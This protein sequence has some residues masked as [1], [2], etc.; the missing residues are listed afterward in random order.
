MSLI[1]RRARCG[2][3]GVLNLIIARGRG[4]LAEGDVTPH[5]VGNLYHYACV[6][7]RAEGALSMLPVPHLGAPLESQPPRPMGDIR[8]IARRRPRE[9]PGRLGVTYVDLCKA[10]ASSDPRPVG[11]LPADTS[12]LAGH[13]LTAETMCHR[14]GRFVGQEVLHRGDGATDA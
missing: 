10:F 6:R 5:M 11:G 14:L 13:R 9:L 3:A 12:N 1:R 7:G 8:R 4:V 2:T